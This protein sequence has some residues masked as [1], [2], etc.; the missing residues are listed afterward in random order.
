MFSSILAILIR[1]PGYA[2]IYK[3]AFADVTKIQGDIYMNFLWTIF[4]LLS[5]AATLVFLPLG[6]GRLFFHKDEFDTGLVY[7]FGICAVLSIFELIYLPF[8]FLGLSFTM[9]VVSCGVVLLSLS[10]LGWYLRY[11]RGGKKLARAEREKLS[12]SEKLSLILGGAVFLWQVLRLTLGAG[13]W[14]IDD[15]WYLTIANSAMESDTILRYDVVTGV[16]YDYSKHIRENFEYIFCPWPLFWGMFAKLFSFHILVLMRTVLPGFF[17]ALFYYVMYRLLSLL[18]GGKREQTLIALAV[19][20][21]FYELSSVAM[22]LRSTWII[23]YP[24]MGKGFGPS[25]LCPVTLLLWLTAVKAP[26]DAGRRRMWLGVFLANIAGCVTASSCA[27]LN[28]IILGCWGLSHII[29]TRDFSCVWKLGLC[30]S[31]SLALMLG[32]LVM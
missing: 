25:V 3:S 12:Q 26:A 20:A 24:W 28:L 32:H 4:R 14:N 29:R 13:T 30:V 8:F 2:I 31:P 1:R 23:C 6:V 11:D 22:N 19:L 7:L 21:V 9:L 15:A 18:F 27:E 17:L 10:V 5:L 16:E